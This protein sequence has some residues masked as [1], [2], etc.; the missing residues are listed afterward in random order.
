MTGIPDPK[1]GVSG[2]S[3]LLSVIVPAHQ[4]APWIDELI[5]SILSCR[6]SRMEVLV[7]DDH[8]TDGTRERLSEFARADPRLRVILAHDRG[9]ANARNIGLRAAT[10]RYVAFADGDDIVAPDAYERLV[11][12][13]ESSGSD[14]AFGDWLKFSSIRTWQPSRNWH[15][16]DSDAIGVRLSDIPAMIRGRA[17]WNKVF[18]RDFLEQIGLRFPEVARSND[19]VPMTTAYLASRQIDVIA[20]CVYLYRDRPG[21]TSMSSRAGV[22]AASRSYLEQ[23]AECA[24]LVAAAGDVRLSATYSA[25]IFDADGWTHMSRYLR[26]I[27]DPADIDGSVIEAARE[28]VARTPKKALARATPHKCVLWTL[29][30]E[31]DLG[32]AHRFNTAE[33]AAREAGAYDLAAL[34][35]WV[36]AVAA[37]KS[38]SVLPEV[39]RN[40]IVVDGLATVILH[41]AKS[42]PHEELVTLVRH[43]GDRGVLDGVSVDASKAAVLSS[44]VRALQRGDSRGVHVTSAHRER[45]LVVDEVVHGGTVARIGGE[46]DDDVVPFRLVARRQNGGER[47]PLDVTRAGGRWTAVIP[48]SAL[49]TGR[50]DVLVEYGD[51]EAV[52][53]Q[54]VV[55]ARM[56]LPPLYRADRVRVMSDRSRGW[57]VVLEARPA[58]AVR[59]IRRVVPQ[60]TS[61]ASS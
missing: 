2:G 11:A 3:P 1:Q 47:R 33:E 36:D 37:M 54:L 20:D 60:R 12:S 14:I 39:D 41:H 43:I 42:L 4:V 21:S 23:E 9:G 27:A 57:R 38:S 48:R 18:R 51:G 53:E 50:W 59:A 6:I 32:L 8:S 49:S 46:W 35:A 61:A 31:G 34:L 7:V 26:G 19:I 16:F 24:R 10:G 30:E 28:L 55:T 58:V 15:A 17:V 25:L 44:L 40:R 56:A 22:V 45:R 13:L 52:V 5:G 29:L